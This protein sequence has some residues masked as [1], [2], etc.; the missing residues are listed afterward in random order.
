MDGIILEINQQLVLT[1]DLLKNFLKDVNMST[2]FLSLI[3]LYALFLHRWNFEKILSFLVVMFLLFVL[4]V[5]ADFFLKTIL[6]TSE[7]ASMIFGLEHIVFG[8][9]AGVIFLYHAAIKS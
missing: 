5:R 7:E 4:F 1:V 6:G 8:L 9:V 3:L 2:V